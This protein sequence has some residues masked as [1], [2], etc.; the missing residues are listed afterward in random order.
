METQASELMG[1]NVAVGVILD[2]PAAVKKAMGGGL[3]GAAL[4]KALTGT[5]L[6][7]ATTPGNYK[8]SCY[9]AVGT[10]S[11]GF[12]TVKQ[13]LFKNSLGEMLAKHPRSELRAFEIEA[14]LMSAVHIVLQDGTHY[15]L[16]CAKI[17]QKNLNK[18]RE[19]LSPQ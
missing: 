14:G 18:A 10:N 16:M 1:E 17:N 13:G 15:A 5:Q 3:V 12:F 8:R 2:S 7:E 4:G 11:I 19:L 6:K 9:M